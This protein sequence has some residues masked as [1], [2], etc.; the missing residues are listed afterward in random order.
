MRVYFPNFVFT[1]IRSGVPRRPNQVVFRVPSMLNKLDIR[2]YLEGVYPG[3]KVDEVVTFNFLSNWEM[4][5]T[6]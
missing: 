5:Q 4:A 2:A 6:L 3:V 1:M